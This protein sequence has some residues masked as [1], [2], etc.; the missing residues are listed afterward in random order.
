LCEQVID[1]DNGLAGLKLLAQQKVDLVLCDL[2]MPELDGF[3][4]LQMMKT[5]P[6]YRDIPVI[7]LTGEEGI[8]AKVKGLEHGASDYVTKP[9]EPAELLARVKVQL[10]LKALQ[11]ELKDKNAQLERL[12][13]TDALT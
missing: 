10:K 11:D 13:A 5:K 1:A 6:E 3:Q 4:F 9:F 12:A 8:D 7:L 2:V